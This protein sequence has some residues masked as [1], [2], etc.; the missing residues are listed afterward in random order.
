[1]KNKNVIKAVAIGISAGLILQPVVAFAYDAPVEKRADAFIESV[2][3]SDEVIFDIDV[4]AKAI[5]QDTDKVIRDNEKPVNTKVIE[6]EDTAEAAAPVEREKGFLWWI[7]II[8]AAIAGV[9]VEE[10]IRRNNKAKVKDN[11]SGN[12]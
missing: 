12:K 4:D 6:D 10:Y 1:M 5:T 11:N 7:L 2:V 9:S 3:Y 8:P